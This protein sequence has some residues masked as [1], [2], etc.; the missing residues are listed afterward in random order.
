M[1]LVRYTANLGIGDGTSR[2]S[3]GSRELVLGGE[4]V[5]LTGAEVASISGRFALEILDDPTEVVEPVPDPVSPP[6]FL[7]SSVPTPPATPSA[8]GSTS[9]TS[10]PESGS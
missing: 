6:S 1:P 3:F 2:I 4:P 10:T 8:S 9:I 5:E 7:S